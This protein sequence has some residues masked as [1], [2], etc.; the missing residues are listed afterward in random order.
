MPKRYSS[1]EIIKVLRQQG[2]IFISQ[3]GSHVKYRKPGNPVL[4][5]IVPANRRQIPSGTFHSILRQSNLTE[6]NFK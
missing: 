4:T 2:F 1:D 5:A 3:K 6:E